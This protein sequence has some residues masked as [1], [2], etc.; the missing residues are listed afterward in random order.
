M[1]IIAIICPLRTLQSEAAVMVVLDTVMTLED[2]FDDAALD[3]L[4]VFEALGHI[5][6]VSKPPQATPWGQAHGGARGVVVPC[7]QPPQECICWA[8]RLQWG[9]EKVPAVSSKGRRRV[10]SSTLHPGP[11]L[12]Q[13]ASTCNPQ[14]SGKSCAGVCGGDSE[15]VPQMSFLRMTRSGGS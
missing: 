7:C 1:G 2:P 15:P 8:I 4:S 9:Q 6:A 5:S 11:A 3:A 13:Q 12:A 10:M 14:K